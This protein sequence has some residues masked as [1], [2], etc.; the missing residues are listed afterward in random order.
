[1]SSILQKQ[2]GVAPSLISLTLNTE[3][4][5]AYSGRV[6]ANSPTVRAVIRGWA[7]IG[8]GTGST[9]VIPRLRRGNGINGAPL[10]GFG[11]LTMA[12]GQALDT[13]LVMAESLQNIEYADY[14]LTI[15]QV[16]ATGD[17][18]VGGAAIEVELI[19]G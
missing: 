2:I 14:S 3:T 9:G 6:E 1:M 5:V 19:N 15:Q 8:A 16:S 4:L 18:S 10:G 7:K 17:G 11:I 12:P 13:T